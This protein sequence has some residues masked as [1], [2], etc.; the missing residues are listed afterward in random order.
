[1]TSPL[2][3]WLADPAAIARFRRR[4]LHRRPVR[5]APRDRAWQALAPDFDETRR[6]AA[7]GVPFHVVA[8]RR[9]DRSGDACTLRRSPDRGGPEPWP[10]PCPER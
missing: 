4:H 2:A 5:L 7:S 10:M 3:T 9:Y 8:D 6:L 1:M